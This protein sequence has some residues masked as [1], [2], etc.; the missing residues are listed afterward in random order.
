MTPSSRASGAAQKAANR[1]FDAAVF[2]M[3]G[4]VT[5]TA[6]VH[7]LAWKRMFDE[8]LQNRRARGEAVGG[9]FTRE[10]Y[11]RFVDGRPRYQGVEAFLASR[12]IALPLGAPTDAPDEQTIC[13]LG[14]RKNAHF[15][16]IIA[17]AGVALFESTIAL[18]HE[19]RAQGIAVGLA[20]SSRNAE[21][22]LAGAGVGDLFATVIDG[23]AAERLQLKGKPEPDIFLRAARNLGAEPARTIVVEDAVSG[24]QAG[25]R[26]EFGLV[27]GVARENNR[28]ELCEHGADLVVSDLRETSVSEIDQAVQRKRTGARRHVRSAAP[29]LCARN[30]CSAFGSSG[31]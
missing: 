15:N 28:S 10:D 6:A 8:F 27:I 12:A 3:D 14:N 13:G 29:R 9:E 22:V 1:A 11:L 26:G 19:L 5:Q 20:T 7:A 25:A 24:V 23:L 17:E 31:T 18:I 4:V 16:A 21:L 30:P 2:D